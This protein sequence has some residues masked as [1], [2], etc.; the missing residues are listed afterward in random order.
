M[1]FQNSEFQLKMVSLKVLKMSPGVIPA[2]AG[3]QSFQ[4]VLDACLRRACPCVGRGMT[5]FW[6]FYELG[7]QSISILIGI[8]NFFV[9]CCT[10]FDFVNVYSEAFAVPFV[11]VIQPVFC[12]CRKKDFETRSACRLTFRPRSPNF[13]RIFRRWAW[14]VSNAIFMVRAISLLEFPA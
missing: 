1:T 5:E 4:I 6:T 8:Y 10:S 13:L 14:T 7:N 11:S 3:I 9:N 2:K 12:E